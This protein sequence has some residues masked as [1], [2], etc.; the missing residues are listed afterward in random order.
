MPCPPQA[1]VQLWGAA[2]TC[3]EAA[4]GFVHGHKLGA[5]RKLPEILEAG[6]RACREHHH[7][8]VPED[9]PAQAVCLVCL[10]RLCSAL[11]NPA[12]ADVSRPRAVVPPRL[13]T[14]L[15][16]RCCVGTAR[17]SGVSLTTRSHGFEL[18]A[19]RRAPVP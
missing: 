3:V 5:R 14:M 11:L 8:G 17:M 7:I 16:Q 12:A 4:R 6:G 1:L 10:Q 9:G 2:H 18:E 19:H 15:W 13:R